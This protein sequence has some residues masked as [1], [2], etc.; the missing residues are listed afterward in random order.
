MDPSLMK[1][2][3]ELFNASALV[4]VVVAFMLGYVI[5]RPTLQYILAPRDQR[6]DALEKAMARKDEDMRK[7]LEQHAATVEVQG[8][9][10]DRL[11]TKLDEPKKAG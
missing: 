1:Q 8:K 4:A 6:I 7:L 11:L 9:V 5:S 3:A 2:L 10:I